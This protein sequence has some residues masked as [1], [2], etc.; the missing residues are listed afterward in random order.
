VRS[1]TGLNAAAREAILDR[2]GALLTALTPKCAAYRLAWNSTDLARYSIGFEMRGTTEI[3]KQVLLESTLHSI[4]Q[5]EVE[6]GPVNAPMNLFVAFEDGQR[7]FDSQQQSTGEITPMDELAGVIRGSGKGLGVIVQTMQ[8]LSR[9]LAPNL[10]TK[11]MGRMGS[12][13]DYA[14]LGADLAMDP[15]QLEWGRRKL[16]PGMFVVQVAEG[17]WRDPFV[18]SAPLIRTRVVVSDEDAARSIRSLENLTTVPATEFARWEPDHIAQVSSPGRGAGEEGDPA[19]G[20]AMRPKEESSPK[21]ATACTHEVSKELLDYLTA[22]AVEPLQN[23]SERDRELGIS[24][25]KGH[26]IRGALVE[27]G[28]VRLVPISPGGRGK[29]FQLLDLTE[30]GR[31]LLRTFGVSLPCGHGRGGLEHQWWC[32]TIVDWLSDLGLKASIEDDKYG[33][34]VDVVT[35]TVDGRFLAIEVETSPGHELEN[36]QKDVSAGFKSVVSLVRDQAA[37]TR[38]QTRLDGDSDVSTI[39]VGCVRDYRRILEAAIQPGS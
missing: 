15:K 4:M 28:L 18:I 20:L 12:H 35:T 25:S 16:R 2:L 29:R 38:V 1:T 33:A 23:C 10:A 9:R 27:R 14:R 24:A 37:V 32:Q 11:I 26:R 17:D 34:R 5:H 22:V 13:E 8:G 6:R 3:V 19:T 36:I 7:F 31:E 21:K 39:R 30:A